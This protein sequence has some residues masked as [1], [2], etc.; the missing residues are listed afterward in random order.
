MRSLLSTEIA[1]VHGRLRC[2]HSL[3][4][5]KFP[6]DKS[7]RVWMTMKNV[8]EV[9][10]VDVFGHSANRLLICTLTSGSRDLGRPRDAHAHPTIERL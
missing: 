4:C 7:K 1:Q 5:R 10:V 2:C 3:E 9:G 8:D 6:S